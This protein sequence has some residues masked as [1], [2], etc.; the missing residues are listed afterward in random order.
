MFFVKN[1]RVEAVAFSDGN[2]HLE[3]GIFENYSFF[4]QQHIFLA[5]NGSCHSCYIYF[6]YIYVLTVHKLLLYFLYVCA[7]CLSD[8]FL[9]VGEKVNFV[10]LGDFLK[11]KSISVQKSPQTQKPKYHPKIPKK[12]PRPFFTSRP[13]FCGS[14]QQKP[15]TKIRPQQKPHTTQNQQQRAHNNGSTRFP[16]LLPSPAKSVR[17]TLRRHHTC[18][19]SS[20]KEG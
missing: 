10:H 18:I 9:Q 2:E 1:N 5:K 14:T 4:K 7:F 3:R 11:E 8:N 13:F 20:W 15:T 16:C 19:P 12:M 6:H 17:M